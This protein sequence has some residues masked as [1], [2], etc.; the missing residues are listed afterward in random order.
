MAAAM[1]LGA[2]KVAFRAPGQAPLTDAAL[3]GAY[4]ALYDTLNDDDDEIRDV[5]AAVVSWILST[6]PDSTQNLSLVPLAAG[7]RFSEW[8]SSQYSHSIGLF[9]T[10]VRRLALHPRWLALNT[11][12]KATEALESVEDLL[13]KAT[14]EDRSLFVEEKQNLF[15]DEVREADIWSRV[16]LRMAGEALDKQL[17]K[18][19]MTWVL[20]GLIALSE[21]AKAEA[22]DGPLG[23]TAK[24][25]AFALGVHVILGAKVV[26]KWMKNDGLYDDKEEDTTTALRNLAEI[27]RRA[28][29]H[30]LWLSRIDLLIA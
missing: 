28:S 22:L 7:L 4:L 11:T 5:G 8:L 15:I 1:S 30:E 20:E 18:A 10:A 24:P 25:E 14:K 9:T 26:L 29:L 23:W 6:P 17:A 12:N 27:G 3:L 19:Y 21:K 2:F 16:L 13:A